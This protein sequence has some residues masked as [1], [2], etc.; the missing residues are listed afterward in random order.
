MK[1]KITFITLAFI[2]SSFPLLASRPAAKQTE[3][4]ELSF[5]NVSKFFADTLHRRL[6]MLAASQGK[7]IKEIILPPLEALVST[8][9]G[10]QLK[11]EGI[12]R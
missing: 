3:R 8:E 12:A 2:F 10:A 6:K 4:T 7:K 11:M 5:K 9:D 1:S